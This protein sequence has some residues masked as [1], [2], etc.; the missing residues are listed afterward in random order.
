MIPRTIHPVKHRAEQKAA[1][2][3]EEDAIGLTQPTHPHRHRPAKIAEAEV[4]VEV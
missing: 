3:R 1:L 2:L 4:M